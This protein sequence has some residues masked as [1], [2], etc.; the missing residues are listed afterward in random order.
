MECPIK[1]CRKQLNV[2][3]VSKRGDMRSFELYC[4]GPHNDTAN[5]NTAILHEG[6]QVRTPKQA[7]QDP[8]VQRGG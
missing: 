7:A 6:E 4:E 1:G 3:Q 5:S 2:R 8:R